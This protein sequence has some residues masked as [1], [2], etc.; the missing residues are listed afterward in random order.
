[1][2]THNLQNGWPQERL[3]DQ[4]KLDR[5]FHSD[6]KNIAYPYV[7]RVFEE[8]VTQGGLKE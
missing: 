6:I 5:W 1:M 3:G 2:D 4:D 7:Y 8:F